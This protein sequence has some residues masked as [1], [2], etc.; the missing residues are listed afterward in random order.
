MNSNRPVLATTDGSEHSYR[1]LPH[2]AQLA[3]ALGTRLA[4]LSVVDAKEQA[5]ADSELR[6]TLSRHGIAGEALTTV[7]NEGEHVAGAILRVATETD[8]AVIALDSRGHGA[9]RHIL[10]GSVAHDLLRQ[11]DRPLLVSGP[12]V[13]DASAAAGPYR[14]VITNDGSPASEAVLHALAPLLTPGRFELTLLRI[15]EHAPGGQDE[16]AALAACEAELAQVRRLLPESLSVTTLVRTIPLGA[17]VDTAI[18]EKAR[19][20]G[21]QAIALSTHGVSAREHVVMGSLATLLLGRST[22]PLIL[23]RAL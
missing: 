9:F 14:I 20:L 19:E 1:I 23:A 6:E 13:G 3:D 10:H 17:G 4:L 18:I 12:N 11:S 16:S 22:L 21:A 8:A 15:H 2:A 7:T 5:Q